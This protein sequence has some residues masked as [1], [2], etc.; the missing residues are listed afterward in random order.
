MPLQATSG[1]A[2][3]DGFGGGVAVVPN[4]IEDVFSTYLYTGT[5]AALTITNNIDTSTYG[6]LTWIKGRSGATGH[7]LTDT[8]RGATKSLA[9]ETTAAEA[10]ETTGLTAF[11]TTGFTIGADADYNTSAATYVSWTFRK[12][13]KFFDVVTYTGDG[14][15]GRT[16][17]HNLGSTPGCIIVKR[18]NTSGTNWRMYHLSLGA[19]YSLQ[20]NTTA[21]AQLG[22]T[23]W[24]DTEP[25]STVFSVGANTGV[26][27]SGDSYVAYL[28]AHDA[29]GFGLEGTDN[30]ISCGTFSTPAYV[31]TVNLGYEPQWILTKRTDGAGGPWEIIDSMRGLTVT[32]SDKILYPN[33]SGAEASTQ[34]P[35]PTSTGFVVDGYPIGTY[36]YIAIR[37]G[38][39]KVPTLG[40]SVF[41]P[42]AHSA[43][44]TYVVD[45]GFPTD[46]A[47][48][49]YRTPS[50]GN[51]GATSD[52]LRGSNV[53]LQTFSTNADAT[54]AGWADYNSS[55]S[56]LRVSG[57]ASWA[58]G[59]SYIFWNFR[60]APGFFDVVAYTGTGVDLTVNHNLGVVPEWV[61]I[62]NRSR[63]GTNW[64]GAYFANASEYYDVRINQ[65]IGRSLITMG[66]L[67][68]TLIS[69]SATTFGVYGGSTLVNYS[70]DTYV[71]YLFATLAGV[72][73]VGSYAGTGTTQTINC[74]FTAGARFVLIKRTDSTGD[75]YVWDTTRGIIAGND[76]YLL[77]NSSAIEVT[78]TDYIDAAATGFELSSTAPAALNA[79]GGTYIFLAIA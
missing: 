23:V 38:P 47:I 11:G 19:T 74:D 56:G 26:N 8:A 20:M 36:I 78:N 68:P 55:M 49:H 1:A 46:M 61:I 53:I 12:Q 28:F 45:A 18:T 44:S 4:Y 70:G 7:R 58:G 14:N 54:I 71:A 51:S 31:A 15:I 3:Y 17:A 75:W 48:A 30:V 63:A 41:S 79:S 77:L 2:S 64:S 65:D 59:N 67:G 52:R 35:D 33:T 29:G 25:T 50:S 57:G 43:S 10:T 27:G 34:G 22:N 66:P 73:K 39:M 32:T 42:V 72:S 62:K 24:D 16:V 9:S 37:R 5:G 76:P 13:P 40:T 21:A 6:G 69:N 60:R